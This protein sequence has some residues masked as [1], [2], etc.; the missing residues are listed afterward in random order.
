MRGGRE[1]GK[2]ILVGKV[3]YRY[4][5][6][7]HQVFAIGRKALVGIERVF[8]NLLP[9]KF[10]FFNLQLGSKELSSSLWYS[11]SSPM[12][13][14]NKLSKRLVRHACSGPAE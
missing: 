9:L 4:I 1:T 14:L 10:Q 3:Q 13:S 12:Y 2:L 6:R 5:H 11:S 7:G 8:R